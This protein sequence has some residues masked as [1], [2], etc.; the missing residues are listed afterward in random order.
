MDKHIKTVQKLDKNKL[1]KG[2]KKDTPI[3]IPLTITYNQFL[4]N[5]GKIIQKKKKKIEHAIS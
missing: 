1:I 2:N 4:P 3:D 5:I